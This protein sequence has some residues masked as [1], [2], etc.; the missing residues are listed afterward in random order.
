MKTTLIP[1]VP[2][3]LSGQPTQMV[4]ARLLHQFLAS[5]QDY[6]TWIKSRIAK[7]EFE[8]NADY[9]LHKFVEQVPHQGS[10]RSKERLEH[11]L[12]LDMAKELAMVERTAKGRQARRYFLDCERQ[13]HQLHQLQHSTPVNL[14]RQ[15]FA[16][17]PG[18]RQ[19]INRQAWADVS[20]QAQAAFH[21]RRKTLLCQYA[22]QSDQ[23]G[24]SLIPEDLRPVW[25]R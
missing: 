19:A 14:T 8:L 7:Y 24:R 1:I 17:T 10:W 15:S 6:S 16:I 13:L 4:Y 9:L 18:Q 2:T 21:A 22:E 23:P 12:T 25:A 11:L 20:G 3:T 5:Q